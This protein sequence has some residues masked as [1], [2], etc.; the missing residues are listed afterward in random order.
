MI[1]TPAPSASSPGNHFQFTAV[2][3]LAPL[4][5]AR[6]CALPD[7]WPLEH[8]AV[9]EEG[10]L[11]FEISGP[12]Q[13]PLIVVQGGIAAPCHPTS[14]PERPDPGWWQDLVGEDRA[15]DTRR[16]RV[17]SF[18]YLGGN[19]DSSGPRH[20][21][22]ERFP[23][24][25]TGDQARAL[26]HLLGKLEIDRIEAFVG[27]SYGGMVA[28]A[29]AAHFPR[30]LRQLVVVS[31][32]HRSHPHA[33]ALRSL[34]R[35]IVRLSQRQGSAT[36][37]L[38]LSRALATITFG[39]PDQLE[40]SFDDPPSHDAAGFRFPVEDYLESRGE[41]FARTYH[42]EA[43]LCLSESIDLHRVDPST[44]EAPTTLVSVRSDQLVP[45]ERMWALRRHLKRSCQ[46]VEIVSVHGHD[47]FLKETAA[48]SNIL[49]PCFKPRSPNS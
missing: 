45:I 47:A 1:K 33:T 35:K 8:G 38:A 3:F 7:G 11:A 36:E 30:R 23:T 25:S 13:A 6:S 42:P 44:I 19:G 29:F 10:H 39:T 48:L 4:A 28:L 49:E 40:Q 14:T 32:A 17:L 21:E 20:T 16:F 12:E 43:F 26:A 2:P 18:D 31:A 34:Q 37:G 15:I 27:A 46:W 9:L 22:S 41:D 5:G 24:V